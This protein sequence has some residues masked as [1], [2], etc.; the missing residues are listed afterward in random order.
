MRPA[1]DELKS[2]RRRAA[3][4]LWHVDAHLDN[5]EDDRTIELD[6]GLAIGLLLVDISAELE[7]LRDMF[8][9]RLP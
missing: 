3:E 4:L 6:V 8:E 1:I 5:E 2:A 7:A 9:D